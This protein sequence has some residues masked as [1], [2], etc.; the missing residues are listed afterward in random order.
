MEI[1][2]D[3]IPRSTAS[4]PTRS[5]RAD[6]EA[7]V[8]AQHGAVARRQL[9]ALGFTRHEIDGMERA[10]WLHEIHP[11]V[12]AVG[13]RSLSRKGR[14]M[15]AV[16]ACGPGALLSH[17]SAGALHGLLRWTPSLI[18][19]AVR[20]DR[21]RGIVG[22]R[23]YLCRR[24]E[25]Q[26]HA[27]VDRIPCTSVAL[28]LLNLA[29][30]TT[31]RQTERAC[32]EAEVQ[33]LVHLQE[34]QELLER[35]RGRRGVATLRGVLAEHDAGSTLTRSE[36][37]ELTLALCRRAQLPPPAVNAAVQGASGRLYTVDFLWPRQRVVLE[38]D[39]HAYHRTHRAVERD[40]RKEADLVTAGLRVLR[41]T[42]RQVSR[43]PD[44][45]GRMLRVALAD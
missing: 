34:L 6:L 22:V 2:L 35:S 17:R 43:E 24:L 29:A 23:P 1:E 9:R 15:A 31:P 19:V 3:E 36:L 21:G 44:R 38:T 39:G 13:R 30:V 14:W 7:I 42:W 8:L 45:I 16:L 25:P 37:E 12:C 11:G 26:D 20:G 5:R 40:R 33:R 4:E 32:D 18:E 10:G 28:T 41:G 27:M